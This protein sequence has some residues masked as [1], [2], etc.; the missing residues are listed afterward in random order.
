MEQSVYKPICKRCLLR[1]LTGVE[2]TLKIIE[3]YK[4]STVLEEKISSSE[5]E[6]RLSI[7]KDCKHLSLGTCLKKGIYVEAFAYR[8]NNHCSIDL[9]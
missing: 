4:L 6:E 2:N 1:E 5:Y 8:K 3:E 9:F 7:C